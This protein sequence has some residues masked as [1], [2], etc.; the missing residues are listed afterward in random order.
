MLLA[1][2][3]SL[4]SGHEAPRR[5]MRRS[6]HEWKQ[7]CHVKKWHSPSHSNP[8][9]LKK[10]CYWAKTTLPWAVTYNTT[11]AGCQS[12][13]SKVVSFSGRQYSTGIPSVQRNTG[14]AKHSE[15]KHFPVRR[16]EHGQYEPKQK[17]SRYSWA[18][19]TSHNET[20]LH[21]ALSAGTSC[22][23]CFSSWN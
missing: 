12:H 6:N 4:T 17:V 18:T 19:G 5:D 9:L 22:G 2:S 14:L 16:N 13:L 23:R 3:Q 20:F 7:E 11:H 15:Q 1:L 21:V 10:C 8:V